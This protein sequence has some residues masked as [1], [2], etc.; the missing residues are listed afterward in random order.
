MYQKDFILRMIEM[1]AD[2]I[3]LILGLIKKGDLPQASQLLENAYREFLKEDAS[4]FRNLPKEELTNELLIK[5]NY[6]NGHLKILAELFFAEGELQAVLKNK[7]KGL[8][9][10][11]KALILFEFTN[12]NSSTFSF[13]EESKI[14]LI[15]TKI[16]HLKN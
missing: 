15:T 11:E 3:A 1:I 10:Y 4:F 14:A 13:S 5:H 2:L 16:D 6:T 8:A 7:K 12:Q 9:Y